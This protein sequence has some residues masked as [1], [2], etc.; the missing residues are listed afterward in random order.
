MRS[1]SLLTFSYEIAKLS[2]LQQRKWLPVPLFFAR[3]VFFIS[4]PWKEEAAWGRLKS[5]LSESEGSQG[6]IGGYSDG[7]AIDRVM[8]QG[9]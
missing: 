3:C 1:L 6:N 4:S 5:E 2:V 8:V 7:K 9:D